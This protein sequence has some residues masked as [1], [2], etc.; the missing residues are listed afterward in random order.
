MEGCLTINVTL[1]ELER[2]LPGKLAADGHAD[3]DIRGVSIDSRTIREGNLYIPLKRIKDG[4][5]YVSE[6]F[7]NGAAAALWQADH[8]DPPSDGPLLIVEDCLEALQ[9][10]AA[11]YRSRLPLKV[12]GVTGSNGKT[13][14][15][16]MIDA[17]LS[18][19]YK[20][21][22]TKGNWNSQIG[23]PL[24]LLEIAPDAEYA[25]IEMG[26]SERGQIERLSA[27]AKPDIA[28]I[29]MIGVSHLST[30]GSREEIAAAKLEI[31]RGMSEG[32]AVVYNGD[33]PL[34]VEGLKRATGAPARQIAFGE[35]EGCDR[36]A[37]AVRAD[38]SGVSFRSGG[39][40]YRIPLLGRH[41][42]AN[43]LAS[44]AVA[45][46][47]GL[48]PERCGEG[49]NRLSL[50]GMRMEVLRAAAGYTVIND[51]WNASPVSVR[52]AIETFGELDG[53]R[54]KLLVL[55]DMR[56][57]GENERAYHR[58]IG[59]LLEPETIQYLFTIGELAKEI[60][61]EAAGRFPA[62]RV[63][64]FE[65]Q[66]AVAEELRALLVSGDVVLVKGS[67]GLELERLVQSVL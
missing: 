37:E 55:G 64:A 59:R 5:D 45:E 18:T 27:L 16:D 23:L 20:V 29:T 62:G 33:E 52:A 54:R 47:V 19:V 60:A 67:R 35:A 53:Y 42:V 10:L 36:K 44:L 41:N 3:A 63:Q 40:D 51:A 43:A 12:I 61:L 24:T 26:M 50:T 38:G 7:R 4:H 9:R 13:T 66:D 17:I 57:L 2:L 49:L 25:V 56:E 30:L 28:V 31:L 39:R 65:R 15:K 58:E 11:A 46:L 21:H 14:T 34:L 32:G 22:K 1:K 8:P 6:A 48:G